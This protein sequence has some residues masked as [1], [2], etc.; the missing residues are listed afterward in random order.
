MSDVKRIRLE[1][2]RDRALGDL[3]SLQ[4]QIEDGEIDPADGDLLRRR[5]RVEAADAMAGLDRIEA[6]P[7]TRSHRRVVAG[8]IT[9]A[10]IGGAAVFGAVQAI[11][12]RPDGGFITGGPDQDE[13]IDL[14]DVTQ[15]EL[16][17]VVAANP[18][19]IPMRLALARRYVEV[20][21]FS[22][23]LPHYLYVLDREDNAEALSYLGWMT[24]LSGD[25]ETGVSLLERSLTILPDD[26][27]S[28]WFLANARWHGLE[29]RTGA[30]PLLRAVIASGEAPSEIVAEAEAMLLE[31]GG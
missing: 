19:V 30:V 29:D 21:E 4:R 25:A 28:Q 22:A 12:P 7:T 13:P 24:Y 10:V 11:E 2:R 6:T 14:A 31:V 3:S 17:A 26:P 9:F 27:V 8:V 18:E 1:E 16:E 20:G 15:E 23:A 5:Y